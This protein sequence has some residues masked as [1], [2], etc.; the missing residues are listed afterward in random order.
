MPRCPSCYRR[1]DEG[2]ACPRDGSHAPAPSEAPIADAKAPEIAGYEGIEILGGGGFSVVWA[3]KRESDGSPVA[4][5][6]GRS[7]GTVDLA[8]FMLEAEVLRRVGTPRAP[9]WFDDGALADGRPF[10]VMERIEG[11]TLSRRLARMPEPPPLEWIDAIACAVLDALHALHA[12]G[13]I[14]RDLKPENVALAG[15]DRVVLLDYGLAKAIGAAGD[16]LRSPKLTRTGVAVGTPEYMA[17]EQIRAEGGARPETDLY[18]FGAL[19]FELFTLR[20]PFVGE[21]GT[22]EHAH[23]ALR[24]PRPSDFAIVPKAYEDVILACLSKD[25][26]RRPRGALAVIR[27]LREARAAEDTSVDS[28]GPRSAGA[29]PSARTPL[30]AGK[31]LGE[32]RQPAVILVAQRGGPASPVISTVKAHRGHVVRQHGARFVALFSAFDTDHPA[33]AALSAARDLVVMGAKAALHLDTVTIRRND[34]AVPAVYGAAV[35]RPETWLPQE[36]WS[37]LHLGEEIRRVLSVE[38]ASAE[39]DRKE[40]TGPDSSSGAPASMRDL[41]EEATPLTGRD[42]VMGMLRGSVREAFE[43]REPHLCTLIGDAGTGKT[44]LAEEAAGVAKAAWPGALIVTLKAAQPGVG[45]DLAESAALLRALLESG[46]DGAAP[47]FSPSSGLHAIGRGESP[48][49]Q[50]RA[51]AEAMRRRALVG[52]VAVI[53]DDAQNANDALLDALEYTTLGGDPLPLWVVVTATPGFERVRRAWGNRTRAHHR[54][55]L[56]PL[57][58]DAAMELAAALLRPAEYPPAA[59]LER[60]AAWAG[61]NPYCLKE[62]VRALKRAGIVRRR[63]NG[64][65]YYVATANLESLPPLPAWQ[66]LAARSLDAMPPE[67]AACVRLCSVLGASFTREEAE[68]VQDALDR[69]GDA[70]TPLD[71]GVALR[72]LSSLRII[73]G[74]E[75]GPDGSPLY[76]FRSAALEEAVYEMLDVA[77]RRTVHRRA[78]ELW[79][80]LSRAREEGASSLAL[81]RIG[82]HATA[83]GANEE[84]AAAYLRLGDR[85]RAR[86]ED[87]EADHAYSLALRATPEDR[88][89]ERAR[90]LLGR[91]RSRYRIARVRE[92]LDD[93]KGARELAETL[94]D[95]RLYAEALLAEATALDWIQDYGASSERVATARRLFDEMGSSPLQAL[96]APLLAAEA[97]SAHRRGDAEAAIARLSEAARVASEARDHEPRMIAL[98]LLSF[99]LASMGRLDESEVTFQEV[100]STAIEADDRPHLCAAYGNRIVL[101]Y[102]RKQPE[103]AVEDLR[104]AIALAREVGNPWLERFATFNV[105]ILLHWSGAWAEARARVDRVR[106]LEERFFDRPSPATSLLLVRILLSLGELREAAE[107]LEGLRAANPSGAGSPLEGLWSYR[108]ARLVLGGGEEEQ[109]PSEALTDSAAAWKAVIAGATSDGFAEAVLEALYWQARAALDNGR[110]DEAAQALAEARARRASCPL[111]P[112]YF[113][114]LERRLLV[115]A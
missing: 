115:A 59:V 81:S 53:L 11:E 50:M 26:G 75:A 58:T 112:T 73:E 32:G 27:A 111:W 78:F 65:S 83:L 5:K 74:G 100:I 56:G 89:I 41:A 113:E 37:G 44:R 82:R 66:W 88:R 43:G 77:Q 70:S 108:M 90:A 71:M 52:P 64:G 103:R 110:A 9:Q 7:E 14:H 36:P 8:R 3:G 55:D 105:A 97:R 4:I 60:L 114:A 12:E 107:L 15:P 76:S 62:V 84:A 48:L 99:R 13:Y 1:L 23:L 109:A 38:Q 63:P 104:R 49:T 72:G 57:P 54:V 33:Q 86:N 102:F 61:G 45:H 79:S 85:A 80:E 31:L 106:F 95:P 93:L 46:G 92:A 68:R 91:G 47:L 19:L 25:P 10:I 34:R 22:L 2:A 20:P 18:A 94:S 16:G 98:L 35:E 30:S 17:P 39:A 6:V 42:D 51:L 29:P 87:T 96:R 101:W 40:I 21:R 67:L 69:A 28:S 24:P